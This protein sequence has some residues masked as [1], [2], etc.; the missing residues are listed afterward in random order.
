MLSLQGRDYVSIHAER[1]PKWLMLCSRFDPIL[2]SV[3]F[4]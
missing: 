2:I 1:S 3:Q 4:Y